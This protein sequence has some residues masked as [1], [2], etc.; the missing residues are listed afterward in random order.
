MNSTI[1][2]LE[3]HGERV[4]ITCRDRYVSGADL[5]VCQILSREMGI[6]SVVILF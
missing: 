5:R 6:T 4:V 1:N 2:P 3:R